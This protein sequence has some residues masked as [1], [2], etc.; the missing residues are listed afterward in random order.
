MRVD[1]TNVFRLRRPLDRPNM[2][3][4]DIVIVCSACSR[5]DSIRAKGN[6][7]PEAAA[8]MFR[9]RGWRVD[10]GGKTATCKSCIMKKKANNPAQSPNAI[11]GQVAAVRLLDDHFDA[12]AGR[13][14]EGW[15]DEA[16]AEK[17]GLA[18]D[19]V[20]SLRESAY[21]PLC[22]SPEVAKIETDIMATQKRFQ[23]D[24]DQGRELLSSLSRDF[25]QQIASLRLRLEGTT[26]GQKPHLKNG[27]A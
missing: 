8:N 6:L 2:G 23:D 20:E 9:N 4:P 22:V 10:A 11:R 15:S 13:Y 21:G 17:V 1:E 27:V 12:D 24:L 26:K 14:V 7:P 19:A 18:V 25:G 16:I 5:T 3:K